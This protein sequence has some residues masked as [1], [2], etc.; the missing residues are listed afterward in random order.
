MKQMIIFRFLKDRDDK[1]IGKTLLRVIKVSSS[2]VGI[3]ARGVINS[4]EF[5]KLADA[6][7]PHNDGFTVS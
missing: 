1:V 5:K 3:G 4:S 6:L 7:E 2:F